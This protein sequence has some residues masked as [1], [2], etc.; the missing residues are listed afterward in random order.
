M[1]G[2]KAIMQK[3]YYYAG[4]WWTLGDTS[5]QVWLENT[6]GEGN[7]LGELLYSVEDNIMCVVTEDRFNRLKQREIEIPP[8]GILLTYDLNGYTFTGGDLE[9]KAIEIMNYEYTDQIEKLVNHTPFN[10]SDV[11]RLLPGDYPLRDLMNKIY[12]SISQELG[13]FP[14]KIEVQ[15]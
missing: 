9:R 8:R 10:R 1:L 12:D 4:R 7:F 14:I 11:L 3:Q 15:R 6:E 5:G 2:Y 13:L